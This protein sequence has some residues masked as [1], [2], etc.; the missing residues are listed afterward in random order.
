MRSRSGASRAV[1]DDALAF[2][3]KVV[4]PDLIKIQANM[5]TT[6]NAKTNIEDLTPAFGD[7]VRAFTDF[8]DVR[9]PGDKT[10]SPG[11]Q[12]RFWTLDL[13]RRL[14]FSLR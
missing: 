4:D 6:T 12:S 8:T 11:K 14:E 7:V 2:W 5:N 1:A 13:Q 3:T 10:R 9:K